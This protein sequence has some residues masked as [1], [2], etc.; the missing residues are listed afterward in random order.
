MTKIDIIQNVY[1][2]L[3]FSKKE[4]SDIVE[5]VFDIIKDSLAAGE[6]VKISG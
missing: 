5:S 2:K 6:R 3:G 4:S 1:E